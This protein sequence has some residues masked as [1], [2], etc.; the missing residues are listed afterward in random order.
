MNPARIRECDIAVVGGGISGMTASVHAAERGAS[1]VCIE[2]S[3]LPGGLVANVGLL[4]GYPAPSTLSGA[5]L[6]D[7][8]MQRCKSLG[9][10]LLNGTVT[11]LMPAKDGANAMTE[12]WKIAAKLVIIAS[13]ARL[14]R[15]GV[16]GEAE[17]MGRGVSQCDWC[18]GGLFRNE[19]VF[20]VGGGDAALQAALH[21]AQLCRSVS[22][23]V[24]G[25]GLRARHSYLQSA[26]DNERIAFHWE[27]VVERIT[28]A[29]HVEALVLR[30]LADGSIVEHPTPGVF[31]FV[32]VEPNS[33]FL[34]PEIDLD[35]AGFIK[36]D[37]D[38]RTSVPG[39][40]AIGGV[41]SGYRGQ[42]VS[43]IGE[44]AAAAAAAVEEL[45]RRELL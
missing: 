10:A 4:G 18:D 25:P 7:G 2:T 1:V 12:H 39:I 31:V 15:V 30:N 37:G 11:A 45:Q 41:R 16:P 32:G 44:G 40:Y 36:T 22:L 28:G 3:A 17:L 13:G 6:A 27:T 42:L 19:S 33:Q 9:V 24:R 29:D 35:S 43:A 8:L 21:L 38:G 26:A 5:A 34:P 14:R 23:I 20:V